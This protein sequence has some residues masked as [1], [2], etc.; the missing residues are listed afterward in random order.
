MVLPEDRKKYL[1]FIDIETIEERIRNSSSGFINTKIRT[2]D[3]DGNYS[4]KMYL[5]VPMG[6]NEVM[7]L[8][9]HANL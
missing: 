6:N 3:D 7:L 4:K 2:L 8:V 5:A 9:R 1:D